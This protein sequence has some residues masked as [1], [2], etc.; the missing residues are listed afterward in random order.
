MKVVVDTN[1]L[2]SGLLFGGVPGRVLS[3]WSEG[4][5]RLVVSPPVLEEYRRVGLDLSK[6]REPL[7]GLVE[8]FVMM[9]TTHA[10][11]LDARPLDVGVS[12]DPDDDMFLA[13]AIAGSA[14]IIVSRDKHLLQVTGWSGIEVLKPRPGHPKPLP[15]HEHH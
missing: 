9:V 11:M 3:A 15:L 14:Q 8:S 10:L 13:A 6:G 4:V 5:F 7:I 1:V 2:M 12:A